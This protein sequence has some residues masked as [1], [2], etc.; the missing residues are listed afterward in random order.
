LLFVERP[1]DQET[2]AAQRRALEGA[3]GLVAQLA[4]PI[5]GW[6]LSAP[7]PRP[8]ADEMLAETVR[9]ALNGLG[10]WWWEHR[11]VSRDLVA[12]SAYDVLWTGI[13]RLCGAPRPPRAM[14]P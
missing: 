6:E 2:A 12:A 14:Q 13:D 10:A 7:I 5:S 4:G 3:S 11:D 8:L 9:S 1:L